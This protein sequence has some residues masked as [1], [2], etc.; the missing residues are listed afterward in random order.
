MKRPVKL[1]KCFSSLTL[2]HRKGPYRRHFS[3]SG[4][5]YDYSYF[6]GDMW[7]F[8]GRSPEEAKE[9]YKKKCF[10]LYQSGFS[11]QGTLRSAR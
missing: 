4:L 8:G 10:S 11:W 5:H 3:E 6:D 2:P 1:T 9:Q 7:Y